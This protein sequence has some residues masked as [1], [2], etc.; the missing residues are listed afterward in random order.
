MTLVFSLR[1][2]PLFIKDISVC[3]QSSLI[4][5]ALISDNDKRAAG[6]ASE[7]DSV[8]GGGL[9]GCNMFIVKIRMPRRKAHVQ[10]HPGYIVITPD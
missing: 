2:E 9:H 5:L 1:R 10:L 3:F 4:C 6:R 7:L 8:E